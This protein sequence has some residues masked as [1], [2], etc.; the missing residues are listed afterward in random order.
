[1]YILY[2]VAVFTIDIVNEEMVIF[3]N[4]CK[5]RRIIVW[6]NWLTLSCYNLVWGVSLLF[7]IK[8]PQRIIMFQMFFFEAVVFLESV[9]RVVSIY[10]DV[11]FLEDK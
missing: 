2:K 3:L 7:R 10:L 11:L 9:I 4:A 6:D 5:N 1:M 8:F